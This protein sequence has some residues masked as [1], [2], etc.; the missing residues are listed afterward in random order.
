MD[1]TDVRTRGLRGLR[2]VLGALLAVA[3]RGGGQ[4][5]PGPAA[6]AYTYGNRPIDLLPKSHYAQPESTPDLGEADGPV[7]GELRLHLKQA[8]R[9]GTAGIERLCVI[10][11][12]QPAELPGAA[13]LR[14]RLADGTV[15][16]EQ[17]ADWMGAN[18]RLRAA[19]LP[20]RRGPPATLG[21]T[22][23][24]RGLLQAPAPLADDAPVVLARLVAPADAPLAVDAGYALVPGDSVIMPRGAPADLD[25]ASVGGFGGPL[26][27]DVQDATDAAAPRTVQQIEFGSGGPPYVRRIQ[28]PTTGVRGPRL[29][30]HLKALCTGQVVAEQTLSLFLADRPPEASFGARTADLRYAEPVKDGDS[31]RPWDQLWGGSGL[32]DVVV[33][34]PGKPYRLVLWRGTSYVPC[35]ALPE[36]WLCYEWLEAE[37]YFHGAVDCVEPIMDKACRYSRAE[38][39]Y[40]SPARAVVTWRYALT[41]FAGKVIRDEH[42]EE[43]WTLYPDGVGTR[44]LRAFYQD[45]WHETQE[46]IL[47]N[48]P[49]CRPS[50]ALDPQALALFSTRGDVERPCWPRPGFSV[51][52]WPDLVAMVNLGAGPKP[53][54]VAPEP[55]SAIK[56][57]ADPYLDKPDLFNSYPHWPVSRGMVTSWLTDAAQFSL[58]THTNLVN[59]V[60]SPVASSDEAKEWVWLVGMAETPQD[61]VTAAACWLKPASVE[62]VAGVAEGAFDPT[63][64]AYEIRPAQGSTAVHFALLP[65]AGVPVLNPAFVVDAWTGPA[66][67]EVP[68]DPEVQTGREGDRLVIWLRGRF[69]QRLVVRVQAP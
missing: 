7:Q 68:G 46:F 28:V 26:R 59:L 24:D 9:V 65:Q 33:S 48:R 20:V 4:D 61:A 2:G 64:R 69:A 49:G 43:V 47:I 11:A 22:D 36:A 5:N 21:L 31:E 34:F 56:V 38:I 15:P 67:V 23:G 37:P 66:H 60:D 14:L 8:F 1:R 3:V 6:P 53:F 19:W 10:E 51:E 44:S 63:G 12:R 39:A 41:D 13:G 54:Q 17:P 29:L 57:W 32:R 25:V 27:I 58:P 30:L 45:G 55:P 52:G 16:W 42:A 62:A 18:R 40:S 50:A 35:W